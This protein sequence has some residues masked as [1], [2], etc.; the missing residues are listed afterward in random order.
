MKPVSD[1][2]DGLCYIL[3]VAKKIIK[4]ADYDSLKDEVL[5]LRAKLASLGIGWED[6]TDIH[7]GNG[8][9]I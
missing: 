1:S 5:R 3:M 2:A 8:D 4:N 7:S 6:L 9:F